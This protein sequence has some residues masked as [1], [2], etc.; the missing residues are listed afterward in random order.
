MEK[1][2]PAASFVKAGEAPSSR[3]GAPGPRRKIAFWGVGRAEQGR[4]FPPALPRFS[5]EMKS[6]DF[7]WEER[8][9]ERR[10]AG[11]PG[12]K[13]AWTPSRAWPCSGKVKSAGRAS[14]VGLS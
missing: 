11:F 10:K 5:M 9:E 3:R 6:G 13:A 8:E 4:D 12:E 2:S 7:L 1:P 14:G